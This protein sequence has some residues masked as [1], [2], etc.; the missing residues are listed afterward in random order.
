MKEPLKKPGQ[1]I[2]FEHGDGG[3]FGE[4]IGG[5]FTDGMWYYTVKGAHVDGVHTEVADSSITYTY[6]GG[7]WLAPTGTSSQ[8]AYQD[9]TS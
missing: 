3:G 1:W 5:S 2:V 8:S 6:E 7:S 9:I 4:I